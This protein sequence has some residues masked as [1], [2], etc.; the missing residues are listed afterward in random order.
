MS[1]L[2]SWWSKV[3][4]SESESIVNGM[5]YSDRCSRVVVVLQ[6]VSENYGEE[7]VFVVV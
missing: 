5:A 6:L 7:K 2:V 1:C 4:I 3:R